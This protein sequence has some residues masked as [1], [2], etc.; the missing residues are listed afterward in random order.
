MLDYRTIHSERQWRSSTGLRQDQFERL[1][2][3]FEVTYENEHGVT[4]D[5]GFKA[6]GVKPS[7]PTYSDCLFFVLFQLKNGLSYDNLGLV[8]EME[9]PTARKN[10]QRHLIT[11]EK[12]LENQ[13]S[14]PKRNFK[15]VEEF[16]KCIGEETEIIFDGCEHATQRPQ[17]FEEQKLQYS[18]KKKGTPI[19]NW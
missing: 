6:L 15:T 12:V 2:S 3:L 18:G 11:L 5:Q 1:A 17:D 10:F 8:F 14:L 16:K 19:K 7:L 9:G 13:G 4:L